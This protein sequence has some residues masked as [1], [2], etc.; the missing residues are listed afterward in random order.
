MTDRSERGSEPGGSETGN[1]RIGMAQCASRNRQGRGIRK[2]C[3]SPIVYHLRKN[4]MSFAKEI[5]KDSKKKTIRKFAIFAL[6]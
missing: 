6:A 5:E 3:F 2:D 1:V 4:P